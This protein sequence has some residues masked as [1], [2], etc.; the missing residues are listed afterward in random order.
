MNDHNIT[1]S[2]KE[3]AFDGIPETQSHSQE[4]HIPVKEVP[5]F[6]S[7]MND[8]SF[9]NDVEYRHHSISIKLHNFQEW[10]SKLTDKNSLHF[11]I[12]FFI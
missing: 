12:S 6:C 9:V 2:F 8:I 4:V 7:K 10:K 1:Q 11:G 3:E 5:P